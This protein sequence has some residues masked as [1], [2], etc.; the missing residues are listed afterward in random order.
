MAQKRPRDND[1]LALST[2]DSIDA[3]LVAKRQHVQQ[4]EQHSAAGNNQAESK[5]SVPAALQQPS[6]SPPST[7]QPQLLSSALLFRPRQLLTAAPAPDSFSQQQHKQTAAVPMRE[8]PVLSTIDWRSTDEDGGDMDDDSRPQFD[9]DD[10]EDK[11][12]EADEQQP[13]S[14]QSGST[15][16]SAADMELEA[17]VSRMHSLVLPRRITYGR[18]APMPH[19]S[20]TRLPSA[21]V[22]THR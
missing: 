18:R 15:L 12:D 4:L 21:T 8:L 16:D 13:Q 2:D 20:T 3:A 19:V 1:G 22:H 7:A 6:S 9:D 10:D 11:Y 17:V 5:D 14:D